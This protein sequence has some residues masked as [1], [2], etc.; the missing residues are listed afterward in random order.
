MQPSVNTHIEAFNKLGQP[1]SNIWSDDL[2]NQMK[3]ATYEGMDINQVY[4]MFDNTWI[5]ANSAF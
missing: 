3:T 2:Y 1:Q 5:D 4:A